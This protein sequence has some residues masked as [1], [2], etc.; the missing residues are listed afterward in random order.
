M[1]IDIAAL[2][3]VALFGALSM[4]KGAAGAALKLGGTIL[5]I[6]VAL[7]IYPLVTNIVYMTPVPDTVSTS[8][9]KVL[10]EKGGENIAGALDALPKIFKMSLEAPVNN[11]VN[12]AVT[13]MT[14]AVTRVIITIIIFAVLVAATKIIIMLVT[15][16]L[17]I[18]TKLPV[19]KQCNSLLGLLCG[20]A[21]SLV[22]VWV[23][24][25]VLCA[26]APWSEPLA[27]EVLKS[28]VVM[29]MSAVSPF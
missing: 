6:I 16:A 14:D 5:S 2:L 13:T 19:I 15:G 8:V 28:R 11:A 21:A 23:G 4:K 17:D 7:I 20:I 10:A 27:N 29:I 26:I 24:V 22:I 25:H 12:S 18:S 3:F 1:I 9:G